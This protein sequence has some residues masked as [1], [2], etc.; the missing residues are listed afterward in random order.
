MPKFTY[1]RHCREPIRWVYTP[2]GFRLALNESSDSD[3]WVALENGK[4]IQLSGDQAQLRRA[5]GELLFKPHSVSCTRGIH[6]AAMPDHVKKGIQR[7]REARRNARLAEIL[8]GHRGR[9][10]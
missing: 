3:G 10:L 6:K 8:H 4:A 1:C 5:R 2:M 7:R 9:S